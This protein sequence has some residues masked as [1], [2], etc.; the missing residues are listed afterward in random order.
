MTGILQKRIRDAGKMLTVL[1]I[2]FSLLLFRIPAAA[3]A[4]GEEDYTFSKD[5]SSVLMTRCLMEELGLNRAAAT[6][7]TANM[8]HESG[9]RTAAVGDGGTSFGLCQW[10][11]ERWQRLI[12]FA[13]KQGLPMEDISLQ[14]LYLKQE[15][16]G[17][18]REVLD[19]L[20]GVPETEQG[21]GE[22]AYRFSLDFEKPSGYE[23]SAESRRKT[24]EDLY[25]KDLPE[26][27]NSLPVMKMLYMLTCCDQQVSLPAWTGAGS[28]RTEASGY[29]AVM[30][31]DER[32]W[33]SI[34]ES[35]ESVSN[36]MENTDNNGEVME[37]S[38]TFED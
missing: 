15:L 26:L 24:A 28:S 38:F 4:E 1:V 34:T 20:T 33:E 36:F 13:G 12:V 37:Y 2:L 14:L 6:G 17:D 3:Y 31:Y 18:Y 19:M 22:A 23:H 27:P 16:E 7:I 29:G 32:Y 35:G 10:H 9:L 8:I 11:S 25:E 5:S 30:T 21:A